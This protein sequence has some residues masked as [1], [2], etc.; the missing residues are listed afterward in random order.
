MTLARTALRMAKPPSKKSGK[1]SKGSRKSKDS[2]PTS[3]QDSG[4]PKSDATVPSGPVVREDAAPGAALSMSAAAAKVGV[5]ARTLQR[6]AA[7]GRLPVVL[8]QRG[9]RSIWRVLPADLAAAFPDRASQILE[10]STAEQ[11]D[12]A[13]TQSSAAQPLAGRSETPVWVETQSKPAGCA[14]SRESARPGEQAA[15]AETP[16]S[17]VLDGGAASAPAQPQV[18]TPTPQAS[19]SSKPQL[20]GGPEWAAEIISSRDRLQGELDR[21]KQGRHELERDLAVSQT[22]LESARAQV[23]RLES[24]VQGLEQSHRSEI[25]SQDERHRQAILALRE[26]LDVAREELSA[27]KAL[28]LSIEAPDTQE[29]RRKNRRQ[30]AGA[31]AAVAFG[32]GGPLLWAS[33]ELGTVRAEQRELRTER[34]GLVSQTQRDQGELAAQRSELDQLHVDLRRESELKDQHLSDLAAVREQATQLGEQLTSAEEAGELLA[35]ERDAAEQF[36]RQAELERVQAEAD[37]AAKAER[38]TDLEEDLTRLGERLASSEQRRGDLKLQVQLES[39]RAELRSAEIDRLMGEF[40]AWQA[41]RGELLE[42]LAS[43]RAALE[44]ETLKAEAARAMLTEQRKAEV[45]SPPPAEGLEGAPGTGLLDT[46]MLGSELLG[47]GS[48]S[49]GGSEPENRAEGAAGLNADQAPE[50][51]GTSPMG[52]F[53][54]TWVGGYWWPLPDLTL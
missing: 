34:D 30:I 52:P 6:R 49:V 36:A 53:I 3:K 15:S 48:P 38:V 13:A 20:G 19:T 42:Q 40:D 33:L 54:W 44:A 43:L 14:G 35:S 11:Q 17:T 12:S 5:A 10:Q 25:N 51:P 4:A 1:G 29:L 28:P 24:Q 7:E 37:A 39:E 46:E 45:P 27:A 8:E 23:G 21:H 50:A 22:R 9:Q 41:E 26:A 32:L 18:Q 47:T 16:N 31:V 2:K